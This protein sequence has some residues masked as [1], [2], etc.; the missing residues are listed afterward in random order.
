M[1][2]N[3]LTQSAHQL[4]ALSLRHASPGSAFQCGLCATYRCINVPSIGLGK[5]VPGLPGGRVKTGQELAAL[6]DGELA[7]DEQLLPGA[8][9]ALQCGLHV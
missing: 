9:Q 8:L 2:R 4:A 1:N 6:G 5:F 7:V 3:Q